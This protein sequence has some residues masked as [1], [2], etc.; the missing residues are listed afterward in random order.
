MFP[1]S[2]F[3]E[4]TPTDPE[5]CLWVE[6][7]IDNPPPGWKV[8]RLNTECNTAISR[9]WLQIFKASIPREM[10]DTRLTGAL[11]TWEGAIFETFSRERNVIP[12]GSVRFGPHWK[13]FGGIDWGASRE[14]PFAAVF[15]ARNLEG[16]WVVFEEVWNN[17]PDKTMAEHLASVKEVSQRLRIHPVFFADPSRPDCIMQAL[18]MGLQVFPVPRAGVR[19]VLLESIDLVRTLLAADESGTPKLKITENCRHC[20]DELR[21]YRWRRPPRGIWQSVA[22]PEPVKRD[23]DTVDALRYMIWGAT[24]EMRTG[25]VITEQV[26]NRLRAL[27]EVSNKLEGWFER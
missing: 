7:I 27:P 14:H 11:P 21:R 10:W 3:A 22:P 23:D 18:E 9:E 24:R 2:C 4:F 17:Q 1:G 26:R 12:R 6:A 20:I 16:E 13:F 15:G 5:L 25:S 19:S 8:Y